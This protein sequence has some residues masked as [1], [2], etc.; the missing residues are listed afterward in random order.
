[1]AIAARLPQFAL[2]GSLGGTATQFGQMFSSGGPFWTLV[3]DVSMPIFDGNALLH[4]ER[5]ADQALIQANAQYRS[6]VISAYQTV[7]DSLHA[8]AADADALKA[9]SRAA[10]A[11]RKVYDI[12]HHQN[13]AGFVDFLTLYAA[14]SAYQQAEVTLIQAEAARYT[15]TAALYQALGGGWWNRP[16]RVTDNTGGDLVLDWTKALTP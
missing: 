15:D 14:D 11:A 12:T 5:A 2:S 7:A 1:V 10:Q 13:E 9:S 4:K 8:V 6:T 16:D 3:G